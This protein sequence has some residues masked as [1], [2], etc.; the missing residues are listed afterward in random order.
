MI[1]VKHMYTT[2]S[3]VLWILTDRS[4]SSW[5]KKFHINLGRIVPAIY[6]RYATNY[7]RTIGLKTSKE[8]LLLLAAY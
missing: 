5:I 4:S 8:V 1:D 3:L 7:D 2:N 6:V